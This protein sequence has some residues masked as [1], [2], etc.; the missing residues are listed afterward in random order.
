[1]SGV[2]VEPFESQQDPLTKRHSMMR[3]PEEPCEAWVDHPPVELLVELYGLVSSSW[4]ALPVV[5]CELVSLFP[6]AL[7]A[8]S[9]MADLWALGGEHWPDRPCTHRTLAMGP[10][11]TVALLGWCFP[12]NSLQQ[13]LWP[14]CSVAWLSEA[15]GMLIPKGWMN[16]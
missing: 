8:S 12:S 7:A 14:P 3:L 11:S 9:R 13:F 4:L 2:E 5:L 10:S 1:M 6:L 15:A 16:S